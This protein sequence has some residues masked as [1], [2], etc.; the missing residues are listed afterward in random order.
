MKRWILALGT[1]AA[2]STLPVGAFAHGYGYTAGNAALGGLVGG[3]VGGLIGSAIAP[4]PVYAAPVVVAPPRPVVVE[5]YYAPAP[6]YVVPY[7][8]P[9][10]YYGSGHR[11]W[12]G[13]HGG[14][15]HGYDRRHH[16]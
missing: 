1:C 8:P 3:V 6:V 9:A 16:D 7:G 2:L 5:P 14:H 11:G 4:Y 12:Y 10:V 15:G 13:G